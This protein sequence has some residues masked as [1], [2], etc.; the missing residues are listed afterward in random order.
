MFNVNVRRCEFFGHVPMLGFVGITFFW[1]CS[2]Q[3]LVNMY[4]RPNPDGRINRKPDGR[5]I[6]QMAE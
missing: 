4:I 2:N 5:I 3:N 6:D 1:S